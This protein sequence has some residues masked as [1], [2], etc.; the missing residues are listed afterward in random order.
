MDALRF[1]MYRI[2]RRELD[3]DLFSAHLK[4]AQTDEDLI[5]ILRNAT[6]SAFDVVREARIAVYSWALRDLFEVSGTDHPRAS[7]IVSIARSTL[8]KDGV[9]VTDAG[10]TEGHSQ[11]SPPMADTAMMI[12]YMSRHLVA[13]ERSAL[14]TGSATWRKIFSQIYREST[15]ESGYSTIIDL[16]PVPPEKEILRVFK[17]FS[18]LTRLRVRLRLP[19]PETSRRTQK[20]FDS[21]KNGGIQE[22]L[23]DMKNP[24]GLSK[25]DGQLPEATAEIAQAGYKEGSVRMEGDRDGKRQKVDVGGKAA[26]GEVPVSREYLR[27][28]KDN[29]KTKEGKKIIDNI[30]AEADRVVPFPDTTDA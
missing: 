19:N 30:L 7:Y 6:Q 27:G 22:Y 21:L 24:T 12:F 3:P 1:D 10:L 20:L 25:E 17:S 14:T 26:R 29:A 11:M 13:V 8:E 4:N 5:A 2:N 9:V 23:Q 18:R 15:Q 28:L 16:E